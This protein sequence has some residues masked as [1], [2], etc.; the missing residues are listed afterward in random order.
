MLY[1]LMKSMIKIGSKRNII[2]TYG[3]IIFN[4]TVI[5]KIII[6]KSLIS[7]VFLTNYINLWKIRFKKNYLLDLEK[8][9]N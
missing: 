9:Q 8:F 5:N 6:D 2:I 4:K 1:T 7:T 3:D